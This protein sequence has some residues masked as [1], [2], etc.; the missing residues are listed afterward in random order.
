MD[1]AKK[2][3]DFGLEVMVDQALGYPC[4]FCNSTQGNGSEIAPAE[5]LFGSTKDCLT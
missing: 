1:G 5:E 2:Q 4:L 3:S